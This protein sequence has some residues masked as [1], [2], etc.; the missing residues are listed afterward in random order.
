[1]GYKLKN[2]WK[3]ELYLIFNETKNNTE[4]NNSSSDFILRIRVYNGTLKTH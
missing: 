2:D 3:F 4:T 1:M